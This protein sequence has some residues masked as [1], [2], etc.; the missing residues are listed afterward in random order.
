MLAC[1]DDGARAGIVTDVIADEATGALLAFEVTGPDGSPR[2]FPAELLRRQ[3]GGRLYF[4]PEARHAAC[5]LAD[6]AW[7]PRDRAT[8]DEQ[9]FTVLESFDPDEDPANLT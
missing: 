5:R 1:F 2:Y 4:G 3:V 7:R 9:E 8:P 6:L